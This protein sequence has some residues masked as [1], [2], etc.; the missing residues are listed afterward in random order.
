MVLTVL[1]EAAKEE[2][3]EFDY[4]LC[5]IPS[6]DNLGPPVLWS[7]DRLAP[8][9]NQVT[10]LPRLCH[11]QLRGIDTRLGATNICVA[12]GAKSIL[13][14]KH[15]WGCGFGVL[16]RSLSALLALA[17]ALSAGTARTMLMRNEAGR[18][19]S[20]NQMTGY[21]FGVLFCLVGVGLGWCQQR[22]E[23]FCDY[24]YSRKD[25]Y[26]STWKHLTQVM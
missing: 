26:K 21:F 13:D 11:W 4:Y 5:G 7:N 8:Y 12:Q 10:P 23:A 15:D 24:V 6:P 14:N 9:C 20:R 17:L 22:H 19:W 3:S 1:H 25:Y 18:D 16:L 2:G